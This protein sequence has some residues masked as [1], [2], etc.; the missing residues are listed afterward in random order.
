[1]STTLDT[2]MVWLCPN[3]G[4]CTADPPPPLRECSAESCGEKFVSDERACEA[5]NRPFTRKLADHGC[6]SCVEEGEVEEVEVYGKCPGCNTL[7]GP[8]LEDH[9]DDLATSDGQVQLFLCP[10]CGEWKPA[11]ELES[12]V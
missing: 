6:E 12:A 7:L 10:K 11:D 4:E 1:L 2:T 9:P 5:C 3:C 8:D